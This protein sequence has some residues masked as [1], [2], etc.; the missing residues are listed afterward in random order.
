M[1]CFTFLY[2]E[3]PNSGV[4]GLRL[5]N[6]PDFDHVH[7]FGAAHDM[8][9]HFPNQGTEMEDEMLAFGA[10][11]RVRGGQPGLNLKGDFEYP[12]PEYMHRPILD[13]IPPRPFHEDIANKLE[14]LKVDILTMYQMSDELRLPDW[15][16]PGEPMRRVLQWMDKGYRMAV[17][18]Y[19]EAERRGVHMLN[20]FEHLTDKVDLIISNYL[21]EG[22]VINIRI[23]A[24][25][26]LVEWKFGYENEYRHV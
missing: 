16:H 13:F 22:D 6:R 19:T 11:L 10:I 12:L 21:N 20:Y 15:L 2:G 24:E 26:Y 14:K 17:T 18:R 23:C 8:I 1:R 9:E 3:D 5:I 25:Q 4:E 7:G